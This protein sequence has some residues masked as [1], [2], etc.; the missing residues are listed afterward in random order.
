[1]YTP[2][3]VRHEI[4]G[5]LNGGVQMSHIVV[6]SIA[7]RMY[8]AEYTSLEHAE[9]KIEEIKKPA[10]VTSIRCKTPNWLG[11][12]TE[13]DLAITRKIAGINVTA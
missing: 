3:T 13:T 2:D 11:S 12:T 4:R 6:H 10:I 7:N 8:M 9:Q 5:R 1:M